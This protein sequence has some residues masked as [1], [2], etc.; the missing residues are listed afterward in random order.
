MTTF[1]YQYA[2]MPGTHT[3]LPGIDNPLTT[4]TQPSGNNPPTDI[5]TNPEQEYIFKK[6]LSLIFPEIINFKVTNPKIKKI[7]KTFITGENFPCKDAR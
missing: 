1:P 7:S 4:T 3:A 5:T 6:F 2:P